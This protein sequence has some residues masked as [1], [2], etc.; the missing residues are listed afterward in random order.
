MFSKLSNGYSS[1]FCTPKIQKIVQSSQISQ[2]KTS[3]QPQ[4]QSYTFNEVPKVKETITDQFKIEVD[5]VTALT[6]DV[7]E[8]A[9]LLSCT[10]ASDLASIAFTCSS[11]CF[12][13]VNSLKSTIANYS[14]ELTTLLNS[15]ILSEEELS[16]KIN[17]ITLKMKALIEE[18]NGKVFDLLNLTKLLKSMAST[19][20][21]LQKQGVNTSELVASLKELV[22]TINTKP[23]D[24]SEATNK[25]EIKD[26]I[27]ENKAINYGNNT[28]QNINQNI[29][30]EDK[31]IKEIENKLKNKSISDKE[32]E[33]LKKELL[34]HK[35][36][37][38]L[39]ESLN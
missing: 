21:A 23:S 17:L 29:S 15:T 8:N 4:N 14:A 1:Y 24:L 11:K 3:V 30:N 13:I 12:S 25:D 38:R 5:N 6:V 39:Y 2:L 9:Q 18:A 27:N 10:G 7:S 32:K 26:K 35:A 33:S 22:T 16:Y 34:I 19:F 37:K 20:I 28:Q 31:N 36:L